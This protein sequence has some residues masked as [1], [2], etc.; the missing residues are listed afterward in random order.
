MQPSTSLSSTINYTV[1]GMLVSL[2][3]VGSTDAG[4]KSEVDIVNQFPSEIVKYLSEVDNKVV[5]MNKIQIALT[6]LKEDNMIDSFDITEDKL[7]ITTF[8][9]NIPKSK[10]IEKLV[11]T[12]I[13]I[14]EAFA[15][16]PDNA[17]GQITTHQQMV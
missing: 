14:S 5:Y 10:D 12:N 15:S 13:A 8:L 2:A 3:L 1:A 9:I 4:T 17:I 7:G 11:N 16:I 6:S